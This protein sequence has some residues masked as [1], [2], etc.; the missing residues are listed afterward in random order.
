M[1]AASAKRQIASKQSWNAA[2]SACRA[3]FFTLGYSGRKI[4]EVLAALKQHGVRTLV[5]IRRNPISV[6]RPE[7]SKP[8]LSKM[9][10]ENYICYVHLPEFGVPSDI[11]AWASRAGSRE[12]IWTW[13]DGHV[14]T[15]H[16]DPRALLQS[17]E[18]PAAFMC[19]ELD[20]R[21]CHRHRLALAWEAAGLASFDL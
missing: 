21:E 8:A 3:D 12:L 20:P 19:T 7:T 1:P 16:P 4:E 11:R 2:R 5:D 9:L 18:S 10:A 15:A 13:Y 6:H 17:F 14:I